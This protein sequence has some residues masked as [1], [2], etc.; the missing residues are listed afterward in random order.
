[1]N[2]RIDSS[3]DE[4]PVR[5]AKR[6]TS[7]LVVVSLALLADMMLYG[8]AVPV[9][10]ALAREYG[11]SSASLG[12][13]FGVYAVAMIALMPVVGLWTD[14][15]GPRKPLLVGLV[16]LASSTLL[17]AFAPG[18]G[19]LIA[20][21][22]LQGASAAVSWTAGLALL[23][24]S[25]PVERRSAAMGKALSAMSIGTLVGPVAGGFLFERWGRAAPFL[26]GA[27]IAAIDA[28]ARILLV[29]DAPGEERREERPR[30][31]LKAEG[32]RACLAM[33]ALGAAIVAALEP[34]LPQLAFSE[35]GA[36]PSG[37]G[38]SFAAATLAS[39]LVYPLAGTAADRLP[40][41]RVAAAGAAVAALGYAGL[42]FAGSALAA[43]AC[44][45]VAAIGGAFVLAPTAGLVAKAA[46]SIEP[47]AY[48]AAYSLYNV[49][50]SVG[51]AAGPLASAFAYGWGG[52]SSVAL[53]GASALAVAAIV[54]AQTRRSSPA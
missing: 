1:L 11:V 47:P 24:A 8:I 20:A 49:A 9:L 52:I 17:F 33:S 29:K 51:L 10:P 34:V 12:F 42:Y 18:Y 7:A 15:A 46:E 25:F 44:L 6:E 23:A 53:V 38:L 31:I 39:V 45:V 21:R 16:G 5:D 43:T 26:L 37:I 19:F 32:I 40:A 3:V 35:F 41:R 2:I 28:I 54:L 36:G 4:R 27:S 13:L 22:A 14:R 48:G 30:S 50:Y